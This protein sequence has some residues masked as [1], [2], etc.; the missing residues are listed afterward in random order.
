MNKATSS[1]ST[2]DLTSTTMQTMPSISLNCSPRIILPGDQLVID[3]DMDGNLPEY[4]DLVVELVSEMGKPL[5]LLRLS[6]SDLTENDV[7]EKFLKKEV[8]IPI[9]LVE[10]NYLLQVVSDHD[11]RDSIELEI[12]ENRSDAEEIKSIA[13]GFQTIAEASEKASSALH[14]AKFNTNENAKKLQEKCEELYKSVGS[15]KLA[16]RS[17]KE[18]AK[19]FFDRKDLKYCRDALNKSLELYSEVDDLDYKKEILEQIDREIEFCNKE[20]FYSLFPRDSKQFSS[21]IK[22]YRERL[23][24]SPAQVAL[25][26]HSTP[27]MIKNWETGKRMGQL[28]NYLKLSKAL[29][30]RVDKLINYDYPVNDKPIESKIQELREKKGYEEQEL[31]HKISV[32]VDLIKQYEKGNELKPLKQFLDLYYYYLENL[33]R[34]PDRRE[35][36]KQWLTREYQEFQPPEL[37]ASFRETM[38]LIAY[39]P[40]GLSADLPIELFANNKTHQDLTIPDRVKKIK[41]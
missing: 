31:A 2:H 25:K 18:L 8:Q 40:M 28:E 27:A 41:N 20:I 10:G 35:W 39:L 33:Q 22:A 34:T 23:A 30:C 16:A 17:W 19:E 11:I 4:I 21:Q 12:V 7:I 3:I 15:I 29:D 13:D 9:G 1:E 26:I 24:F 36:L 32:G 14:S 37:M 6:S 5:E 38:D